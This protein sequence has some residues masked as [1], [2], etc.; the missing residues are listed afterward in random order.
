VWKDK[1]TKPWGIST[2]V[3]GEGKQQRR[4]EKEQPMREKKSQQLGVLEAI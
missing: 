2:L 4:I 3:V 1:R